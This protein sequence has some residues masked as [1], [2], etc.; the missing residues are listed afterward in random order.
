MSTVQSNSL[1]SVGTVLVVGGIALALWG[2]WRCTRL[3]WRSRPRCC[4]AC[5]ADLAAVAGLACPSCGRVAA[6]ERELHRPVLWWAPGS[7]G[8]VLA[9]I[10]LVWAVPTT[11]WLRSM[12]VNGA[13]LAG[14]VL[15][16]ASL[17]ALA[18][19]LVL[20]PW[21]GWRDRPRRCPR[22]RYDLARTEGRRCSECGYEARSERR[23][24]PV[25]R[26]RTIV[27]AG[28]LALACAHGLRHAEPVAERGWRAVLPD[29]PLAV[30]LP[31]LDEWTRARQAAPAPRR[32]T[33]V[34]RQVAGLANEVL[35]RVRGDELGRLDLWLLTRRALATDVEAAFAD[36]HWDLAAQVLHAAYVEERLGSGD[37]SR[38]ERIGAVEISAPATWREG[39][40]VFAEIRPHALVSGPLRV[41]VRDMV[42]GD[43]R[44]DLTWHQDLRAWTNHAL[45]WAWTPWFRR[46][47]TVDPET[48]G[49]DLEVTLLR[50]DAEAPELAALP[51]DAKRRVL[52]TPPAL[53]EAAWREMRRDRVHLP[54]RGVPDADLLAVAPPVRL[55]DPPAPGD[56]PPA[57][58]RVLATGGVALQVDLRELREAVRGS[59]ALAIGVRLDLLARGRPIASTTVRTNVFLRGLDSKDLPGTVHDLPLTAAELASYA[60]ADL[61][62]R[63]RGDLDA[64]LAGPR[65]PWWDG[66]IVLPVRRGHPEEDAAGH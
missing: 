36:E 8:L 26:R 20:G 42:T 7:V 32:T 12:F 54:A 38:I 9:L 52:E 41:I 4:P 25:R 33:W 23:L 61:T 17:V 50:L 31:W 34:D 29:I 65:G 39:G 56:L 18:W 57:I 64:V 59:G 27:L 44:H 37:A 40:A 48:S 6:R 49:L 35:D 19:G 66:E 16:P 10:G 2:W 51:V 43:V 62:L 5:R 21:I 11:T 24:H 53:R 1:A 47:G 15:L 13:E 45:P 14:L 63:V 3:R 46:V 60:D 30:A 55:A 58:L 22:C 28:L